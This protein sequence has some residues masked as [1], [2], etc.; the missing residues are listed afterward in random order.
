MSRPN[1]L[2]FMTDQE[3]ADVCLPDSPCRTPHVDDL[4]R[5]GV[6]FSQAYCPTA[7]CCPSRA[8]FFTGL[9]P[10]RHGV[11][12]NVSNPQAIHRGLNPGVTT[13]GELVADAGYNLV[14]SGKWH[15]SDLEG[16]ADRGWREGR[17]TAGK[18]GYSNRDM[19]MWRE[20]WATVTAQEGAPRPRGCLKRPGWGTYRLYGSMPRRVDEPYDGHRDYLVVQDGIQA[21]RELSQEKEPWCL[22]IGVLGP[23]DPYIIPERYATMYDPAQVA[24]PLSFNDPLRDKPRVYQ[25]MRDQ[26]WG[27][28]S[29][30]EVRESIAHYWSYCTMMDDMFGE[31]LAALDES[32][33]RDDTLVLFVSDHGDYLGSHG[34]YL[35]GVPAFREAYHVPFVIRW[36]Q[37]AVEPGRTCDAIVSLADVFPTI[38]EVAN[39]PAPGDLHGA[40]LLPFLKGAQPA[41]WRSTGYTQMNG[42]ELY[43]TQRSVWTRQFRYV[44]NG[45]DLDELY[46]LKEDPHE[47]HNLADDPRYA[48]VKRGMVRLL[49]QQAELHQ[50]TIF[51]PYPT[52]A[53]APFGPCVALEG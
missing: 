33:A 39:I 36:P 3:R 42:V 17:V 20:R 13:F 19:D 34:L 38:L 21:L 31:V 8:T 37:G 28:L 43:Y 10:S 49:W 1:I 48:D 25:R 35:K 9:F 5:E 40:S 51:N 4:A 12:N 45:F 47:V 14:Y 53:L 24:L 23:H 30:D 41:V 22:F 27:Q 7:H 18:G 50:D 16:P 32:G 6:R 15:V 11:Y 46:D 29:P 52:A 44:Y 26:L 2:I